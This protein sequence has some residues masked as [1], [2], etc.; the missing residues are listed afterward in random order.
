MFSYK[1]MY[2]PKGAI[3][4]KMLTCFSIRALLECFV[5]NYFMFRQKKECLK[6]LKRHLYFIVLSTDIYPN[7]PKAKI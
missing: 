4:I 6:K 1:C 2:P 3:I 5:Y 7:N